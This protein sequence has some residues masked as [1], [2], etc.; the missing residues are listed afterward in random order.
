MSMQVDL[1]DGWR[2]RQVDLKMAELIVK[3]ANGVHR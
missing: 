1:F 3:Y 2:G